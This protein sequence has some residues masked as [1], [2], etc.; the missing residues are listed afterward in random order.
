[1]LSLLV[2]VLHRDSQHI[3]LFIINTFYTRITPHSIETPNVGKGGKS[4]K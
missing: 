1:M 4:A 3:L 2:N